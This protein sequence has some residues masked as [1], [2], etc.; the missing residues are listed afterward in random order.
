MIDGIL[1][2][3]Y[4]GAPWRDLPE[5]FG[6]WETVYSRFNGW[7]KNGLWDRVLDHLQARAEAT[8]QINWEMFCIDSSVVR[9]HKAAAGAGEKIYPAKPRRA[10]RPRPGPVAGRL[11][12]QGAPGLRRRRAR[13]GGGGDGRAAA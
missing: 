2:V 11:R 1:W 9:A 7:R 4:A 5:F 8:G 3:L 6:P 10:G 13:P 12:H